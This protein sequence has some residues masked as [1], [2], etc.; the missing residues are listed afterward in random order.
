M[1]PNTMKINN[2]EYIRAD[3]VV[4]VT[5]SEKLDGLSYM[6]VRTQSAGV[7]AGYVA[8]KKGQEVT[9]YKARRLWFWKGA[10]SLS[11]AAQ[12]GF[13]CPKECKFPCEV[14][15]IILLQVIEI[16]SCTKQAQKSIASVPIWKA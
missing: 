10:A 4:D 9:L 1:E 7:F 5:T 2:V 6:I 11:Q 3:S 16:L 12:E 14:E 8:E 15:S 13:S